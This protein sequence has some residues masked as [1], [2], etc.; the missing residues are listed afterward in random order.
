MDYFIFIDIHFLFF[1]NNLDFALSPLFYYS[2][3]QVDNYTKYKVPQ[4]KPLSVLSLSLSSLELFALINFH[5]DYISGIFLNIYSFCDDFFNS[6]I[7]SNILNE[8]SCC[9]FLDVD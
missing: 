8:L 9:L 7:R 6:F 2:N 5:L 1:F 3:A 4:K